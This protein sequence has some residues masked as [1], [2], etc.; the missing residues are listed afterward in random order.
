MSGFLSRILGGAKTNKSSDANSA[1]DTLRPFQLLEHWEKGLGRR[2]YNFVVTGDDRPVLLAIEAARKGQQR[3]RWSTETRRM[4]DDAHL[5]SG[6]LAQSLGGQPETLARLAE[7][8]NA[9]DGPIHYGIR[10]SKA[11]FEV[12]APVQ[13][14]LR[15]VSWRLQNPKGFKASETPLQA[16][17]ILDATRILGATGAHL[18][19]SE[20]GQRYHQEIKFA[21]QTTLSSYLLNNLPADE[22][23][24]GLQAIE[25]SQKPSAF[26]ALSKAAGHR[27]DEL[28][29]FLFEEL[30]A[31]SAAVREAVRKV[32]LERIDHASLEPTVI[33]FFGGGSGQPSVRGRRYGRGNPLSGLSGC[34]QRPQGD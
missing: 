17:D 23:T 19:V 31:G 8:R 10:A 18:I 28:S 24:A 3:Q 20:L 21:D 1:S 27:V 33:E 7:T 25:A 32:L 9:Q 5:A 34:A 12:P 29:E 13:T 30:G 22:L 11:K 16:Q 26:N 2:A 6:L 4:H 14:M 15:L